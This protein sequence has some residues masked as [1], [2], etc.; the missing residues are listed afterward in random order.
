MSSKISTKLSYD[1]RE[2][3]NKIS[4]NLIKADKETKK[5]SYDE[6]IAR[7]RK[8]F[9]ARNDRYIEFIEYGGSQ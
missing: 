2:F 1:N 7:M 4:L 5:I 8:Y 3:L 6:C 9:K